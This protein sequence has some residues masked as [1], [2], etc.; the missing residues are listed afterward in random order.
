[1]NVFN[2]ETIPTVPTRVC[3]QNGSV[4]IGLVP[5]TMFLKWMRD[6]LADTTAPS[7]KQIKKD[8]KDLRAKIL[9]HFSKAGKFRAKTDALED[10]KDDKDRPFTRSNVAEE[11][12]D[13]WAVDMEDATCD[14]TSTRRLDRY[15]LEQIMTLPLNKKLLL[16]V[17]ADNPLMKNI[18]KSSF[19]VM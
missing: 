13:D 5:K 4:K 1:M 8:L 7:L 2:E 19:K 12:N 10:D 3:K 17:R 16:L 14:V 18:P 11:D 9:Y 15:P 6:G